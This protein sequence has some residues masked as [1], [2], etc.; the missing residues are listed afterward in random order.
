MSTRR[1]GRFIFSLVVVLLCLS[2]AAWAQGQPPG[3]RHVRVD[4]TVAVRAVMGLTDACLTDS[5][6]SLWLLTL[7]EEVKS[8]DWGRMKDILADYQHRDV[9]A[10][11]WFA[12]PDGSYYTVDK[13][14]TDQNLR[15]RPYFPKAMAGQATL[16]DLVVGKST[17][18][19]VAVVTAPVRRGDAVVGVLGASLYL[20]KLS[21]RIGNTL[22]LPD[23][24]HFWASDPTGKIVAINRRT[25]RLFWDP[26]H[27]NSPT[28]TQAIA[29]MLTRPQGSIGYDFQGKRF[30][31]VYQKSPLTGWY[32]VLGVLKPAK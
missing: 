9:E 21:E 6:R 4:A 18:K 20:D 11:V 23:N 5:A 3:A 10:A 31:G 15:D 7:T 17:G 22:S 32:F 16:G 13:G 25:E 19:C 1:A 8:G 2:S 29:E 27:L 14:L 24:I 28:L 26:T 12:R 30:A